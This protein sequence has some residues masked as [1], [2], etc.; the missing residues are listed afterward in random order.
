MLINCSFIT[1]FHTDAIINKTSSTCRWP[2]DYLNAIFVPW[3]GL[4]VKVVFLTRGGLSPSTMLANVSCYI[5][6]SHHIKQSDAREKYD[7]LIWRRRHL[8]GHEIIYFTRIRWG[9][10]MLI[11]CL[12]EYPWNFFGFQFLYCCNYSTWQSPKIETEH[13]KE[14][15]LNDWPTWR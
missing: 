9:M 5:T 13:Y 12:C 3:N 14:F 2:S 11:R 10:L 7:R 1:Y 15:I 6:K 8:Y 4:A